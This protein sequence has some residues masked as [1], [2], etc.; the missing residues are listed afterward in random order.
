[1]NTAVIYVSREVFDYILKGSD[2]GY[3]TNLPKDMKVLSIV[4]DNRIYNPLR[5]V[6][7]AES[8]EF[9]KVAEGAELPVVDAVITRF[10]K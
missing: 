2:Y 6:I 1:M 9:P 8:A 5:F 10:E 4:Q 3:T 7:F